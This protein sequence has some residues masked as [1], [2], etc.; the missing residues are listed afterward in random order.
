MTKE[1]TQKILEIL[2]AD[3]ATAKELLAMQPA[4]AAKALNEKG[5]DCTADDLVELAN[6]IKAWKE[7]SG[8]LDA[9]A[10]EDVAGGSKFG[11]YCGVACG[12]AVVAVA[13]LAP[14]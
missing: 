8:E 4:D 13:V 6:G 1:N 10:L 2:N 14:W 9:D 5:V 7:A 12:A 3:E 11:F